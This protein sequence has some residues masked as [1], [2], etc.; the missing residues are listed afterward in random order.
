MRSKT[1]KRATRVH[2]VCKIQGF[3]SRIQSLGS[4]AL[5]SDLESKA[6]DP[7]LRSKAL[8]PEPWI[9]CLGSKP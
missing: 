1:K 8:A 6:L 4:K 7:G 2:A 9:Q 3:G 5:D